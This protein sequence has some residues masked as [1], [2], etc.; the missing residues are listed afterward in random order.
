[1][2]NESNRTDRD[3]FTKKD[4]AEIKQVFEGKKE[5]YECNVYQKLYDHYCNSGE[6]PYGIMKARTGDPESWIMNE[7]DHMDL[8]VEI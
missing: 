7:L 2:Y 5:L 8:E 3:F 4:L 6:M 1:M